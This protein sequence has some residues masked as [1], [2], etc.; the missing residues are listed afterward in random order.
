MRVFVCVCVHGHSCMCAVVHMRARA[1]VSWWP[2]RGGW[3]ACYHVWCFPCLL[4]QTVNIWLALLN[5]TLTEKRRWKYIVTICSRNCPPKE[6]YP[7][8][9]CMSTPAGHGHLLFTHIWLHT[10][11]R[12]SER[13]LSDCFLYI[14]PQFY[15]SSLT[16]HIFFSFALFY[17]AVVTLF[18]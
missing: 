8:N 10:H 4:F 12:A 3:R 6:Y 14:P 16:T 9:M 13:K 1:C 7:H 11:F 15:F 2:S 5:H 17:A 18:V